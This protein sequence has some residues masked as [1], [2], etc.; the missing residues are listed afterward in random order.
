[1]LSSKKQKKWPKDFFVSEIDEGFRAMEEMMTVRNGKTLEEAFSVAFP[2]IKFGKTS[3]WKYRKIWMEADSDLK[4]AFIDLGQSSKALFQHF[5]NVLDDPRQWPVSKNER[6][7]SESH[8]SS[9]SCSSPS[10]FPQSTPPLS[11][12]HMHESTARKD[13]E[14][15]EL[16]SVGAEEPTS[17]CPFCDEQMSSPSPALLT[18]YRDLESLTWSDP[19][20]DNPNHRSAKSFT[21]F[22]LYCERHRFESQTL[23]VA[24][25]N[26]WPMSIDFG[27]L[28][29]R[30]T[31][32]HEDLEALV[33]EPEES[34]FFNRARQSFDCG[35]SK[36]MN[37]NN[38]TKESAG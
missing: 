11:P 36:S 27:K 17:L 10:S 22:A 19:L 26:N 7:R 9:T 5:L 35:S 28:F 29:D 31:S 18:M 34:D 6:G 13:K 3:E 16:S 24:I 4:D 12:I 20:P 21:V 8:S 15:M 38:F 1:M 32:Y 14:K 33:E 25:R 2:G 37:I 23:P 30:V